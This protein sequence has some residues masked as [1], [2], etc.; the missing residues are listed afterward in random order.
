MKKSH[1]SIKNLCILICIML[2]LNACVSNSQVTH[3][4]VKVE[5]QWPEINKSTLN[6]NLGIF[7]DASSLS[8]VKVGLTK[9]QLYYLLGRPHYDEGFIG[10]REWNYLFHFHT[11]GH[12]INNVTT[13]Q[14]KILF[15]KDKIAQSFYWHAIDSKIENCKSTI[16]G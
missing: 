4:G 16:S 6:K 13:C 10:V 2:G 5:P 1:N 15:D 14:F 9:D 11:P 12:G 8:Q 3:D 7:P